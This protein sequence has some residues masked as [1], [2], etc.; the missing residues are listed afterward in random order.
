[1]F[2]ET[3][4]K[5]ALKLLGEQKKD[6]HSV[7]EQMREQLSEYDTSINDCVEAH[8][9]VFPSDFFVI[10]ITKKERLMPNVFRHYFFARL[11]CPT[12]D[13]DQTVYHYHKDLEAIDFI[14][15]IPD[16]NTCHWFRENALMIDTQEKDL[17]KLVLDFN[18]GTLM[19][20][21]KQLNK[22]E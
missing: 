20:R 18:D 13:Y 22:E 9:K 11:S 8:K 4:G 15:T 19:K 5:L 3:V 16:R 7:F 10:V 6:T 12:P 21:A 17:L 2:R 1:M 14:W